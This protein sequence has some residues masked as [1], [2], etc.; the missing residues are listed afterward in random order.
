MVGA[1]VQ[2]SGVTAND[3]TVPLTYTVTAGDGTLVTYVVTVTSTAY[4]DPVGTD[5]TSHGT[6]TGTAAFATI[7]Y[8]LG[9]SRVLAGTAI[10]VAPGTYTE[11]GQIVIDRN[12]T[13]VGA[14]R[15][16]TIIK[17]AQDTGNAGD[18][19]GWFLVNADVTFNLRNVTLDGTGQLVY[20]GLY[21]WGNGAIDNCAIT[22]IRYNESGPDYEGRGIISKGNVDVRD[23][24][25]TGYGRIGIQYFGGNGV[26]SGNTVTGSG[27]GTGLN[28]AVE[29]GNGSVV[30][31]TDNDITN[32]LG[33]LGVDASAALLVTT[34]FGPGTT[35]IVTGNTLTN[36][37]IG[38]AVGAD[39][40]DTSVVVAHDN[41]I[42]GNTR[43]VYSAQPVI[44]AENN[45]WG[46]ASG[47]YHLT[48][49]PSGTGNDAGDFVD[50][51]PWLV[52][53]P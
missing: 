35:A 18:A 22:N 15:A 32:N 11:V 30:A 21:Y 12:L 13:L 51:S 16:T 31:V 26:V 1:T 50:F 37:G 28:Y 24:T 49:N 17:P 42:V 38:I 53:V 29:I 10:H 45:W 43:G 23:S 47:P 25:F 3:F 52:A 39:A 4:V 48:L 7:Q 36:N 46:D 9:D 8:A 5:D 44:D 6:A 19:R 34:Y 40:A 14:D 41:S 2:V 33:I 27:A 20:M